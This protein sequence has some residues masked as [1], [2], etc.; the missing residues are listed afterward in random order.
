[1]EQYK[2]EDGVPVL[3]GSETEYLHNDSAQGR[4]VTITRCGKLRT[5]QALNTNVKI[6]KDMTLA[7]KDRPSMEIRSQSGTSANN[8]GNYSRLTYVA[9]NKS[10]KFSF[11]AITGMDGSGFQSSVELTGEESGYFAIVSFTLT[12]SVG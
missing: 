1:M 2:V 6:I 7:V 3:V 10:G 12:Y 5:I 8:A 4:Y 11:S 9:L